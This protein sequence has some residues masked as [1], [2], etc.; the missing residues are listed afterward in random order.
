LSRE[1]WYEYDYKMGT[2]I[3][4]PAHGSPEIIDCDNLVWRKLG[5]E[6]ESYMRAIYLGQGSWEDLDYVTEEEAHSIL[7]RWGYT[8][9]EE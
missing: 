3:K 2:L 7:T 1:T 6:D 8:F 9:P 4:C 5:P